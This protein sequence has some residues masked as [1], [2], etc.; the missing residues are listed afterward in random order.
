M[1]SQSKNVNILE[2]GKRCP[3]IRSI[4]EEV[5]GFTALKLTSRPDTSDRR[6]ALPAPY[7]HILGLWP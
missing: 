4:W 5:E 3:T 1:A 7:V 6:A 2:L